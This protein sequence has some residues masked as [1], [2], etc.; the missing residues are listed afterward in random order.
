MEKFIAIYYS[1]VLEHLVDV[2]IISAE[3]I[4]S[5]TEQ[6]EESVHNLQHYLLLPIANKNK[7]V[8]QMKRAIVQIKEGIC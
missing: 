8:K 5:A 7:L 3:D 6:V 4:Y 2:E 1:P